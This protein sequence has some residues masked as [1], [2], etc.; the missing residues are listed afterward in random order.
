MCVFGCQVWPIFFYRIINSSKAGAWAGVQGFRNDPSFLH[1]V[2]LGPRTDQPACTE[3]SLQLH[4][5]V[6][7]SN[8]FPTHYDK[9]ST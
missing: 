6:C 3:H 7:W 4:I 5:H 9:T 8:S 1:R 2:R